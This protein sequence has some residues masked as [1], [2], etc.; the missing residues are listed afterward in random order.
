MTLKLPIIALRTQTSMKAG[1]V[2]ENQLG[3]LYEIACDF[4]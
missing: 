3:D 1:K 2:L 4:S